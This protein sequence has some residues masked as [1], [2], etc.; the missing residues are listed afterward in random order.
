MKIKKNYFVIPLV[1]IAT[2]AIG[3]W[4]TSNGMSWY[5]KTL[6]Q[7][8]LTPP[9]WA[10]PLAWNTIFILVAIS[11][12]IIWNIKKNKKQEELMPTITGLFIANAILNAGWSLLFFQ[13]Q[14][15]LPAFI[16]MFF[17][18]AS[19][20]LLVYYTRKISRA[21]SLLLLPYLIWVSFAT[22]LTYLILTL[23]A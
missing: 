1:V 8:S 16:E 13:L 17:L 2:A 5:D 3:G 14:G 6:I 10:F 21:A 18:I 15:I 12:L 4:F 11:A 22:Y 19:L 9:K 7:P 23:N 20:V